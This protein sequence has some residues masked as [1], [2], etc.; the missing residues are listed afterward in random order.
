VNKHR[1]VFE[2]PEW[3][4]SCRKID[5]DVRRWDEAFRWTSFRIAT[6]PR[7][8]TTAFLTEDHRIVPLNLP[9]VAELYVYFRIE[10]DDE[11]C[12][13]LWVASKGDTLAYRVG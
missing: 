12:T 1:D 4:E 3:E 2:G 5:P 10:S 11:S 7:L 9:G 8:G 13:L 6:E